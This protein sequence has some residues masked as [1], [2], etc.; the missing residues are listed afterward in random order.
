MQCVSSCQEMKLGNVDTAKLMSAWR[1]LQSDETWV[2]R[3]ETHTSPSFNGVIK[4]SLFETNWLPLHNGNA[5]RSYSRGTK[6]E[7]GPVHRPD[8]FHSLQINFWLIRC[9][10]H[11]P[12]LP[13][14]IQFITTHLSSIILTLQR[15]FLNNPH[16]MKYEW[17]TYVVLL[18]FRSNSRIEEVWAGRVARKGKKSKR[19]SGFCRQTWRNETLGWFKRTCGNNIKVDSKRLECENMDWIHVS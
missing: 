9:L 13:N 2:P 3:L 17:T 11:N 1:V 7:T 6:F 15:A 10:G 18:H 12:F 4:R 16:K 5:P 14:P 8:L 19:M